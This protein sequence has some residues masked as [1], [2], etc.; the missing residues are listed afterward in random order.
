MRQCSPRVQLQGGFRSRQCTV[1][2]QRDGNSTPKQK[3]RNKMELRQ[4]LKGGGVKGG[5]L[6]PL[7]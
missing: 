4:K 3:R 1:I 5:G 7:T 2:E 6:G